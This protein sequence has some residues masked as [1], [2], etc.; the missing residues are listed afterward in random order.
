MMCLTFWAGCSR[1]NQAGTLVKRSEP[2]PFTGYLFSQQTTREIAQGWR[3]SE[4]QNKIINKAYE[5]LKRESL[6]S[7]K[8]LQAEIES[9]DAALKAE[10][11]RQRIAQR[12]RSFWSVTTSVLLGG[13][14]GAV[15]HNNAN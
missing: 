14:I 3:D 4:E 15:I 13:V 5:D 11:K 10:A 6:E 9:L 1:A 8:A 2:A 7:V 12:R